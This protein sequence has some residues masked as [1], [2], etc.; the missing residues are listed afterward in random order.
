[1]RDLRE[2]ARAG[3][4]ALNRRGW[5]RSWRLTL[6]MWLLHWLGFVVLATVGAAS[7]SPRERLTFALAFPTLLFAGNWLMDRFRREPPPRAPAP[8]GWYPDPHGRHELR[9]WDATKWT[10][11]VLDGGAASIERTAG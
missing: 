10:T 5:S 11:D 8:R 6:A 9:F 3:F 7:A 2:R 4:A 1:M